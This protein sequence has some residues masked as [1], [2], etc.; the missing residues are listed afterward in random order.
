MPTHQL[1]IEWQPQ[2]IEVSEDLNK[3]FVI[4]DP[5]A[6]IAQTIG[7]PTPPKE[8]RV[9]YGPTSV[10]NFWFLFQDLMKE[11]FNRQL[12]TIQDKTERY[13]ESFQI[14]LQYLQQATMLMTQ[15]ICELKPKIEEA[16][17]GTQLPTLKDGEAMEWEW[18]QPVTKG[19]PDL[20]H[21]FES[22][23]A[24]QHWIPRDDYTEQMDRDT[25]SQ[26]EGTIPPPTPG[27]SLGTGESASRKR[28]STLRG[29]G[30]G[31]GIPGMDGTGASRSG[32]GRGNPPPK[33]TAAA[34]NPGD[35]SDD[36]DRDPV[37]GQP[38]KEKITSEK[39]LEKYITA[40]IKDHKNRDKVEAPKPQPYKG[41]PEDLERFLRQLENVWALEPHKYKKDI[42]KIRYAANLLHR[43]TTDKHRDPVKWYEAYHPKID[44]AAAQRLP[45][46]ARATLDP[47]WSQWRVFVESLRSS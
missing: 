45:G 1:Q 25:R 16:I 37:V 13:Y 19:L 7:V 44:L 46:G 15:T 8:E 33:K 29:T 18:T 9:K 17:A 36:S 14:Q 26:R 10:E 23:E 2:Q 12:G 38:P 6:L 28:S 31:Y 35:S 32:R 21:V 43:N 30:G 3:V 24:N 20:V 41:D 27:A 40:I 42:T 4:K 11:E 47:V 34:G 39:L 5:L 22:E